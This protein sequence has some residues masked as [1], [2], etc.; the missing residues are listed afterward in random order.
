MHQEMKDE[1]CYV[2]FSALLKINYN[3]RIFIQI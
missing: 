3:V 2:E 1:D